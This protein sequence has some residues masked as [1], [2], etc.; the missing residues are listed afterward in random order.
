MTTT[1]ARLWNYLHNLN[2]IELNETSERANQPSYI[3][4]ILLPHQQT[5][6]KA[7]L[8]LEESK[9]TGIECSSINGELSFNPSDS[10]GK[11]FANYGIL[12]DRVGSGKSLCAL[13]IAG[14]SPPSPHYTEVINRNNNNN[15]SDITF[16]NNK[17]IYTKPDGTDYTKINASL[18][19]VPH[20]VIHQWECYLQNDTSL[21]Y[22]IL[23][24]AKDASTPILS[25]M[26]EI[27]VVVVSSTMWRVFESNNPLIDFVWNR[28]FIDEADSI[29][30]SSY[31][32]MSY[33]KACFYWLISA[34]WINFAFPNGAYVNIS[35]SYPPPDI[36]PTSTIE[37][38]KK[39]VS[40]TSH[41]I[42]VDGLRRANIVRSLC[43]FNNVNLIHLNNVVLQS[44]RLYIKNSDDFIDHS[45]KFPDVNHYSIVCET[46]SNLLALDKDLNPDIMERLHAGDLEGA[47]EMLGV[48][49]SSAST[50]NEAL[51]QSLHK[52]LDQAKKIH[53][54][55]KTLEYS[56]NHAKQKA[57]EE[58][59]K[60]IAS[61]E[62]RINAIDERLKTPAESN[63]P[64]CFSNVSNP[65]LT[66]CC[67]NLFC[68][69][70][71]CESLSR[72]STCPLCRSTIDSVKSIHILGDS[73][74]SI[75]EK[76]IDKTKRLTKNQSFVEF[77]KH[78]PSARIL[79]F[80][81]FDATF[82]NLASL[83]V[84]EKIS[85]A[86]IQ[87]SNAHINKLIKSFEE[88]KYRILF[89]NAR[90]MG[91][92]LNILC[93]THIV[94][95]HKMNHSLESQIIGRAYRIGRKDELQVIHLLH[96]NE[97]DN[98]YT[99]I[100]PTAVISNSTT[101]TIEHV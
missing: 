69:P 9:I 74:I 7:A 91:A 19:I 29:H 6:L 3:K 36:I 13:A 30:F 40:Q 44:F 72:S 2:N 50:I 34:S 35:S 84:S 79:M 82:T 67:H 28:I 47:F 39:M 90:N 71:I 12:C 10:S 49:P 86:T 73:E 46:P 20:A 94:L 55:K 78:N 17:N 85:F 11:L 32:D 14:S 60:K 95:Y 25:K 64:I 38:L 63:C 48:K 27:D 98:K 70:C 22:L 100:E 37:K 87:G 23:K 45:F 75:K 54:F 59:E 62:S 92:G 81:G 83:L 21:R 101:S 51:T 52:E 88:N 8:K 56:S 89:L 76:E 5:T 43:G 66:P 93:A 42:Y 77:V 4:Q 53:E 57:M 16:V 26:S 33:L 97:V 96:T 1:R 68:F 65:C 61:L 18:F 80:S 15:M 31:G 24:K 41:T 99:N 58:C